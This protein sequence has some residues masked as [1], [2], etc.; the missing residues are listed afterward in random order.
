MLRSGLFIARAGK[1]GKGVF[2]EKNI[3]ANTI[4]EIAPVIVLSAEDRKIIEDTKLN[5]Y[6]FEWGDD[7]TKAVVALGY[8][9]MYNHETNSSCEYQ[10]DY[11]KETISIKTVRKIKAGEE[12]TINYAAGQFEWEHPWH[13]EPK[14]AKA[15][16]KKAGKKKA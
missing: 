15:P 10:M 8:V 9:S 6:I 11:K 7:I 3:P 1:K 5:Y 4:I 13:V 14:T 12:I 16:A 2:T